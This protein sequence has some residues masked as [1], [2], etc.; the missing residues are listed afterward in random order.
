MKGIMSK[1]RGFAKDRKGLTLVETGFV[2]TAA[3]TAVTIVL[4]SSSSV[5][6]KGDRSEFTSQFEGIIT[7]V[8]DTYTGAAAT[9]TA[10]DI[11]GIVPESA[12]PGSIIVNYGNDTFQNKLGGAWDVDLNGN[13]TFNVTATGLD[14]ENCQWFLSRYRES[15]RKQGLLAVAVNTTNVTTFSR[16]AFN[17]ACSTA[18]NSVNFTVPL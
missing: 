16:A 1:V 7:A 4:V 10:T 11:N 15:L 6:L 17:T 8:R 5:N 14:A 2:L 13:A 9:D 18:A 12:L 3:A